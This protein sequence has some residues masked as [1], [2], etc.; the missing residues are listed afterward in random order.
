MCVATQDCVEALVTRRRLFK[1]FD[2]HPPG[3]TGD[4][5]DPKSYRRI[6]S[7]KGCNPK[8]T[9]IR[10]GGNFDGRSILHLRHH[11]NDTGQREVHRGNGLPWMIQNVFN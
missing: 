8:H 4:L 1:I 10:H 9:F 11:G 5:R 7:Q 2:A 6:Y 3:F